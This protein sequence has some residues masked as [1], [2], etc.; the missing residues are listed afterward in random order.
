M[1]KTNLAIAAIAFVLL[2]ASS[3]AGKLQAQEA[4]TERV[5]L[6][7][8]RVSFVPPAGFK[9]MSK[10]DIAFKFGRNGGAYAPE[11][12]Y[13][14]EQQNVSVAVT[15]GGSGF[16]AE[17]LDE[18]KKFLESHLERS[19]PGV[20]WIGREI[21]TREGRRW[22]HLHLKAEAVDTGIMNDLYGTLFDG[23]LLMFNF[24]STVSQYDKHKESL[25]KSAETI[26]VK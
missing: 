19:I 2:F 6:R 24:N 4:T 5:H 26:S 7:E 18:L 25:R 12:V 9:P 11:F 8:G 17:Q 14:N 10:E 20:E 3:G 16:R 22:I 21:I 1:R 15:F 13:S 23:Q